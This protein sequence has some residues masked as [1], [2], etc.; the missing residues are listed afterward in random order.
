MLTD[1]ELA[2]QDRLD[3]L[4]LRR[5]KKMHRA[6]DVAVVGDGHGFLADAVDVR[7]QLFHIAGAIQQ[8]VVGVQ[9]KMGKFSHGSDFILVPGSTH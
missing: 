4:G 9:M 2:A 3:A 5:L 8:R 7:H 6:V 1:V